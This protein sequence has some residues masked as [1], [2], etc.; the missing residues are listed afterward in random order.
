MP[1]DIPFMFCTPRS[2]ELAT[3]NNAGRVKISL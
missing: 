1:N 3:A 2:A